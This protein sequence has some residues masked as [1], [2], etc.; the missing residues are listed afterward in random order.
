M[1]FSRLMSYGSE[2]EYFNEKRLPDIFHKFQSEF[3]KFHKEVTDINL[4]FSVKTYDDKFSTIIQDENVEN[5]LKT[6]GLST[7]IPKMNEY[8]KK[9]ISGD[10]SEIWDNERETFNLTQIPEASTGF[11]S[12]EELVDKCNARSENFFFHQSN[13][14]IPFLPHYYASKLLETTYIMDDWESNERIPYTDEGIKEKMK[15]RCEFLKDKIEDKRGL[16]IS[17]A[18]FQIKI[19]FDLLGYTID[20]DD[21]T[22]VTLLEYTGKF[23]GVEFIID[24]NSENSE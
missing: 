20:L 9:I 11:Y 23:I 19:L 16:S 15:E 21:F 2:Y 17:K 4:L 3:K 7:H 18:C 5:K 22:A 24:E 1:V 8:F 14:I 10:R 12:W 13:I 6:M